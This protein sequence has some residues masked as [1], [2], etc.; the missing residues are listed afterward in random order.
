MYSFATVSDTLVN[1]HLHIT[2]T[3]E[4]LSL[5]DR[6]NLAIHQMVVNS[7]L[8]P[9]YEILCEDKDIVEKMRKKP[10]V[11]QKGLYISA[12]KMFCP[13]FTSKVERFAEL[14]GRVQYGD[15]INMYLQLMKTNLG[16]DL[17]PA[18]SMGVFRWYCNDNGSCRFCQSVSV[19]DILFGF[20]KDYIL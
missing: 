17:A 4:E 6:C 15:W 19:V 3:R 9:A 8:P 2:R 16:L 1:I 13:K 10:E 5:E 18:C 12:K 20:P 11:I 7:F 14:F